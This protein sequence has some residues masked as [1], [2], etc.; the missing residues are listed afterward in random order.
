MQK[1]SFFLA[2]FT[3]IFFILISTSC[4]KEEINPILQEEQAEGRVQQSF[5]FEECKKLT[6]GS[7]YALYCVQSNTKTG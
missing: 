3:A 6:F 7:F 5:K 2:I 4:T 1:Q